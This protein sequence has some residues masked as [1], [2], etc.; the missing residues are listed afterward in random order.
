[1]HKLPHAHRLKEESS[2][3]VE[4]SVYGWL[5]REKEHKREKQP[6][7]REHGKQ[8]KADEGAALSLPLLF[9]KSRL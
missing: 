4:A 1:M 8:A 7:E 9:V 5:L 2:Q 6:T 3:F